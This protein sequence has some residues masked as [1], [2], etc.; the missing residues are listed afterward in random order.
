M[1][2][3]NLVSS[4]VT[5]L[6]LAIIMLVVATS[7]ARAQEASA[8][9][10][11]TKTPTPIPSAAASLTPT[12][13]RGLVEPAG[14]AISPFTQADL[15][16]LTGNVQRPNGIFWLDDMLYAACSGDWTVYQ[17][18]AE[19][20]RTLTYA[21][22][23][24]NAH[25]LYAEMDANERVWIWAADFQLNQLT[26]ITRGEVTPVSA[27]L[28]GPWGIAYLNEDEFLITNLLGDNAVVATRGGETRTVIDSLN[29]PTGIAL[30]ADAL[31]IGNNGST[32][33]AIERYP[34]EVTELRAPSAPTEAVVVVSG[35]QNVTGLA[36]GPD[37][38]LYF[39]YALGTRG[40]V[41]RVDAQACADAGGC[42]SADVQIVVYTEL[43]APLAGLTISR[44]GRLYLHTMFAPDIYWVDLPG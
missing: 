43:A 42:G 40:V 9:P 30:D 32:R 20:G 14:A 26:R 19:D 18:G 23:I 7:I 21:S 17:I 16:V 10:A 13:T 3:R 25:T 29:A 11:P 39:A 34:L 38:Y 41:G 31:Y 1:K 12:A 37:G 28:N 44:S 2:S 27:G 36:L 33:R 4:S 15:T 5:L 8:T 35:V 6:C 22:G 24:R